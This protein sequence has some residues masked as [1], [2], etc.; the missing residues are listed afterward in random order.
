MDGIRTSRIGVV[1]M[2]DWERNSDADWVEL[3]VLMDVESQMELHAQ[4]LRKTWSDS[5]KGDVKP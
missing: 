1:V 3:C 2:V 5:D 4:S